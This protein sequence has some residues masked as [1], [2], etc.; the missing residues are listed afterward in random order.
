MVPARLQPILDDVRPLAERFGASGHSLYLV[1]GIVRDLVLDRVRPGADLDLTT[2]AH[3]EQTRAL[4]EGWADALWSQGEAFGTIGARKGDTIFE[5][6]TH[7]AEAYAPDSR[8][9]DVSFAEEVE[10]DLSR[11][12]FTVNA[13]AGSVRLFGVFPGFGRFMAGMVG[14]SAAFARSSRC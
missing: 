14:M 6:T 9:P 1:G 12:D 4:L 8:K 2:D 3:P 7:R 5:I 10:S 11:R 13:L